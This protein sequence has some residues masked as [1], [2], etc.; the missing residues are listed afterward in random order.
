MRIRN[1]GGA[2]DH[3]QGTT[4][5]A[6]CCQTGTPR[7]DTDFSRPAAQHV[8]PSSYPRSLYMPVFDPLSTVGPRLEVF[9]YRL[10]SAW[11]TALLSLPLFASSSV[12]FRA[13][14]FWPNILDLILLSSAHIKQ[15]KQTERRSEYKYLCIS[16]CSEDTS[17]TDIVLRSQVGL[18]HK[19]N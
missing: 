6:G 9:I 5:R 7:Q 14:S 11:Q 1:P 4:D 16:D 2:G 8:N 18:L 15:I 19:C 17:K 12:L 3:A 10:L 13:S